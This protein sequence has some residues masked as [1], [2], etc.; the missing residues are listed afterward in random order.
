MPKPDRFPATLNDFFD[1]IVKA[2]TRGRDEKR[3]RDFLCQCSF[4]NDANTPLKAD[5]LIQRIKE[6]DKDGGFFSETKWDMMGGSYLDWWKGEKSRKAGE[7]A[8]QRKKKS[9]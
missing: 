1:K 4:A 2:Q 6:A 7:S 3:L 5:N 9:S 8:R